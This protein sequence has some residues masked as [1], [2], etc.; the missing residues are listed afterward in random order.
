MGV[1]GGHEKHVVEIWDQMGEVV[2]VRKMEGE[3]AEAGEV[4]RWGGGEVRRW[5]RG[6]GEVGMWGCGEVGRWAGGGW[7]GGGGGVV[8]ER[9]DRSQLLSVCN[10]VSRVVNDNDIDN[11]ITLFRHMK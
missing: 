10:L 1:R 4:E 6:G 5:G 11:E 9:C 3:A 7:G 2:E 8:W